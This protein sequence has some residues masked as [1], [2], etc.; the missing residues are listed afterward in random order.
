ML[1]ATFR[2]LENISIFLVSTAMVY[3]KS[4]RQ[5]SIPN[6]NIDPPP[7]LGADGALKFPPVGVLHLLSFSKLTLP[8][9]LLIRLCEDSA[10]VTVLPPSPWA[11]DFG[12]AWAS[13]FGPA[14]GPVNLT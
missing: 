14:W 13:D 9:K 4:Q 1:L 12:L 3:N 7:R 11:T 5:A 8:S 10:P 2:S 6:L